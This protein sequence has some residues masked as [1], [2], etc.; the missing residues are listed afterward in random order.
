MKSVASMLALV[1][2][3][4]IGFFLLKTQFTKGP[5]GGA[6]PQEQIDTAGVTNDLVAIGQAE[7]LYLASH[8]TYATIDQ[9]QQ[10]GS[11]TFSG[12]HRRG[13]N[14]T[15]DVDDGQHFK[16]TAAPEDPSKASWPAFSVD[17]TMQV[18]R[19]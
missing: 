1:V 3:L 14:Y 16:I 15:A 7:R 2:V 18:T 8:G 9:L 17:E 19:Q 11:I 4:A 6:P 12:A 5:E 10:D 13:Y